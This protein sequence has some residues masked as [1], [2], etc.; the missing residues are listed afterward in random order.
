MCINCISNSVDCKIGENMNYVNIINNCSLSE[1]DL[2]KNI[3]LKF[4]GVVK[5]N[6]KPADFIKDNE[7]NLSLKENSVP[8]FHRPYQVPYALKS[9]VEIELNRLEVEGVIS[10]VSISDWASPIVVVPKKNNNIRICVDVKTTLNPKLQIE[11][12]PLPRVDD[13]FNKLSGGSVFTV[14]DLAEAYLQLQVAPESRK[15]LTINTHKGLYC[16]NRL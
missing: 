8:I 9:A 1:V 6:D 5:L 4:P 11:Q 10:K 2:I 14:L 16:F 7:V 3:K 12:H 13:V 15:F